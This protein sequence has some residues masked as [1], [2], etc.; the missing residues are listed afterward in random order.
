[1][2][3]FSKL[4]T[5][6]G[7]PTPA[8]P[9]PAAPPAE[10]AAEEPERDAHYY[11]ARAEEEFFAGNFRRALQL[12]SRASQMDPTDADAWTGQ[13]VSLLELGEKREAV[14]WIT[15]ALNILPDH[16][17]M[18]AL[19]GL[20]FA[21]SGMISRGIQC[22]DYSM[23][24]GADDPW[25]WLCRGE[26]LAMADNPNAAFCMDK[27]IESRQAGH[28]QIPAHIGLFYLKR[29][30]F[31]LAEVYLSKAVTENSTNPALWYHLG[32]AQ[33]SMGKW[34]AAR[35]SLETAVQLQ[36]NFRQAARELEKLIRSPWLARLLH[37]FLPRR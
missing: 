35:R 24:K 36:P 3:R 16:P 10:T 21:A 19:Q 34:E 17:R 25:V 30:L 5:T 20:V 12:F 32:M 18:V 2:G 33:V 15:R 37:R 13:I 26:I 14:A 27:A 23:P 7:K 1:M 9:H 22:S 31:P 6:G 28:W 11:C 29:R 8:A 4:E